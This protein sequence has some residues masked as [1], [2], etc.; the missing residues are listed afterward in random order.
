[1]FID[2]NNVDDVIINLEEDLG[3][4]VIIDELVLV[5]E[6]TF[7]G[8]NDV[9]VDGVND[10]VDEVNGDFDDDNNSDKALTSLSSVNCS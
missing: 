10:V 5:E 2:G 4:I 8:I 6:N 9:N 1:M 7:N 3:G